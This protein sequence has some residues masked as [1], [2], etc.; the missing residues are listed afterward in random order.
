MEN[1]YIEI[2]DKEITWCE[3]NSHGTVPREYQEGFIAGLKQARL[4]IEKI[5]DSSDL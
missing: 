3:E 4:L 2:I 1:K 5:K